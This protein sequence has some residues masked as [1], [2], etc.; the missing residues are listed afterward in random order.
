MSQ[1]VALSFRDL[2]IASP[3]PQFLANR[4]ASRCYVTRYSSYFHYYRCKSNNI[5]RLYVSTKNFKER[6][7]CSYLINQFVAKN[8]I[9]YIY[10]YLN[11]PLR[12]IDIE[13]IFYILFT[14]EIFSNSY[15]TLYYRKRYPTKLELLEGIQSCRER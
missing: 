2:I 15:M 5:L 6:E 12:S 11:F 10:I 14:F 7:L 1:I 13:T 4:N 3:R 9:S 8:L